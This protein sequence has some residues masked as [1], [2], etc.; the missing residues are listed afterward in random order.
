MMKFEVRQVDPHQQ[1]VEEE[2]YEDKYHQEG[3]QLKGVILWRS[4]TF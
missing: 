2:G 1:G 3:Q 4:G